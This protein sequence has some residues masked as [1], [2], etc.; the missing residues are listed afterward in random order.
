MIAIAAGPLAT[1]AALWAAC[2]AWA[3]RL[4]QSAQLGRGCDR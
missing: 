4:S 1:G 2:G 3:D